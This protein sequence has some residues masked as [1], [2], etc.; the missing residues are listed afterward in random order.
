VEF[1]RLKADTPENQALFPIVQGGIHADLRR[2]A[3]TRIASAG[4]W[5][6]VAIG[7]LSVGEAK[8]A[9]HE[10]MEVC[11]EALPREKPRYLMGVGFPEDLIEGVARGVDLFDCVAPTRMGRNNAAFTSD[12]RL[13]LKNA[14]HRAD[15][16]PIEEGCGCACCQRFSRAY[17]RHLFHSDEM[18]GPRLLSLH[19]V[20][21]LIAMMRRARAAILDGTFG[22]WS[23]DW[24]A[25][26][27]SSP[28]PPEH[29]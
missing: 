16:R 25:R 19:N 14:V 3:A 15:D 20:H 27:H 9:M 29:S 6:G 21:F 5:H 17:I 24:L 4:E 11:D 13:N 10:M 18:L 1:S 26:Y 12:G 7:G 8:P 2:D 23:R 28:K 22:T